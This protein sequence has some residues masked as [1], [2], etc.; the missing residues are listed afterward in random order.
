MFLRD[1]KVFEG[2]FTYS[3]CLIGYIS[4]CAS[5]IGMCAS[6]I[7]MCASVMGMCA[8]VM[9]MCASVCVILLSVNDFGHLNSLSFIIR[10]ETSVN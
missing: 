8:S 5:V 7:G 2:Q 10:S 9:G 4:F 3:F 6:V 1:L